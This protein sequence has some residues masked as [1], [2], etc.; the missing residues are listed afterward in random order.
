M[1]AVEEI[2]PTSWAHLQELLFTDP[3]PGHAGEFHSHLIHRG[4]IDVAWKLD[5]SLERLAI[6]K[7]EG[8][9]LRNFTKYSRLPGTPD[10]GKWDWLTIGQ[11]HG[12]PTRLLDWTYSPLVALHFATTEA[13]SV[14]MSPT[15]LYKTDG[16]VWHLDYVR[17]NERLP[18][19]L[20]RDLEKQEAFAATTKFLDEHDIDPMN[21]GRSFPT[22]DPFLLIIEPPSL[23]DRVVNQYAGLSAMSDLSVPMIDWLE[24][25]PE[26]IALK[27]IIPKEMK[28]EI[29]EKL[30]KANI[31][32]RVIYPGLDGLSTWL[33]RYYQSGPRSD[34][35]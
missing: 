18:D 5:S 27:I 9:L 35:P 30:D 19:T 34:W 6:V 14:P 10:V 16:V 31:N 26:P 32:E 24:A 11:H 13:R 12:L 25:A 28:P 33:A 17:A 8:S 1:A 21:P 29:R 3:W 15:D 2:R 7:H 23:D 22:A 20:K 4:T